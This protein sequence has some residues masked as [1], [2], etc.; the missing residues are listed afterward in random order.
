MFQ[1]MAIVGFKLG[2]LWENCVH[3]NL[4]DVIKLQLKNV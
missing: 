1:A 3:C 4:F 2:T